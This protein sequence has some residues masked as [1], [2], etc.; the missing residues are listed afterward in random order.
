[1]QAERT[2][3][4][5]P[6]AN[7]VLTFDDNVVQQDSRF[8]KAIDEVNILFQPGQMFV[9][10]V[11]L[12]LVTSGAPDADAQKRLDVMSKVFENTPAPVLDRNNPPARAIRA[13]TA[14]EAAMFGEDGVQVDDVLV[15][16]VR[17]V[18]G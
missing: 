14:A 17:Q 3:T 18:I 9:G 1:V 8:K 12:E 11:A 15:L 2:R 6:V 16:T 10:L 5:I 7:D 13:A 4:R